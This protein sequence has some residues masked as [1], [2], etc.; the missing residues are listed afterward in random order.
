MHDP[1]SAGDKTAQLLSHTF[2]EAM[3][4]HVRR[5][6]KGYIEANPKTEKDNGVRL[7]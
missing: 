4:D 1:S 2:T 5:I 6:I 7:C 3:E